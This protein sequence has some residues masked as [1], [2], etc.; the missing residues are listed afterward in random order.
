M[1]LESPQELGQ[2]LSSQEA[3]LEALTEGAQ[4]SHPEIPAGVSRRLE[5]VHLS[6]QTEEERVTFPV[7][8]N[9]TTQLRHWNSDLVCS[10]V[11]VSL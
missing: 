10:N 2:D 5:D 8:Y 3:K 11:N 6:M 9:F 1:S 7:A 4:R